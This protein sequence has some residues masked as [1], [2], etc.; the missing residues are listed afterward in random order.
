MNLDIKLILTHIVGFLVTVWILRKFAWGPLLGILEERRRKIKA[1]FDRIDNE[2]ADAAR[3]KA[4][5][6]LK[7]KGIDTLSRQKLSEAVNEGRKIAAEIK[8]MGR[9]E[10]KE[11]IDRAKEELI[12]EAEKARV[13]LKEDM[14][15]MTIAAAEKIISAKLD[16]TE[17][18]RLVA[19]YIDS[20]EKA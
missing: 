16:A 6:E 19:E 20:V 12:H 17:H 8:D 4:D 13:A 14:V 3:I 1:E 5:Y 7:L 11:L 9:Q 2:K 10:S 15:T 18:R